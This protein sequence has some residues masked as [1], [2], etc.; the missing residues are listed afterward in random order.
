MLTVTRI[1]LTAALCLAALPARAQD[2][3]L[4]PGL[5]PL[6]PGKAYTIPDTGTAPKPTPEG[7]VKL[8]FLDLNAFG[9][10]IHALQECSA[11]P[12]CRV[13]VHI[14]LST[15]SELNNLTW[16]GIVRKG[17]STLLRNDDAFTRSGQTTKV[18][19]KDGAF[20]CEPD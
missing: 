9:W 3:K 11:P 6:P 4:P 1:F 17:G 13:F 19:Y 16:E 14:A 7:C 12:W 10:E 18:T 2:E 8:A 15:G 20:F 5:E